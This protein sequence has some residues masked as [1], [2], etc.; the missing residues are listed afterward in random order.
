MENIS[1][2]LMTIQIIMGHLWSFKHTKMQFW[3]VSIGHLGGSFHYVF[4]QVIFIDVHKV[5]TTFEALK[6]TFFVKNKLVKRM[7]MCF[8]NIKWY[9]SMFTSSQTTFENLKITYTPQNKLV[10]DVQMYFGASPFLGGTIRNVIV[11][12]S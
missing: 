12:F 6:M 7:W 3:K 5:P 2:K 4:T 8:N 10:K 9:S 11:W 1:K